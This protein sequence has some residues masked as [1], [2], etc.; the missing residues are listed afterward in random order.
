[1]RGIVACLLGAVALL[2]ALG[3]RYP[4][5]MIPVL[6]FE[7]IWK[8]I[9]LLA[10]A[11]PLYNIGQVDENIKTSVFETLFGV[12]ITPLLIPWKYVWKHYVLMPADRWK[13]Q[14]SN[15]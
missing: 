7:L 10:F 5:Q 4:L 11:L 6:L 9:W 15:K 2:S 14:N 8:I 1:M 13:K 12:I 3:I